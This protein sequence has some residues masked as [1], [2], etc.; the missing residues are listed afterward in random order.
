M[1]ALY[2]YPTIV[3]QSREQTEEIHE[4]MEIIDL[5]KP[6]VSDPDNKN[7][8]KFYGNTYVSQKMKGLDL[9]QSKTEWKPFVIIMVTLCLLVMLLVTILLLIVTRHAITKKQGKLNLNNFSNDIAIHV[10]QQLSA[11]FTQRSI[12]LIRKTRENTKKLAKISESLS[13][14]NNTT[15]STASTINDVLVIVKELLLIH[16]Q[17]SGP[18]PISCQDIKKKQLNSPSGYYN[19]NGTHIYCNM[20][21][22]CGSG[23]GW[24]R[25]AYLNMS[26]PAQNCPSGLRLYLSGAVRACSRPVSNDGSCA[27]VQF[28]SNGIR[29]SQI[30][31]R[32]VGYQ[33]GR[34]NALRTILCN[35]IS[36]TINSSY[37][38]GVS[39]TRG[40]SRQHVWTFA[41]GSSDTDMESD[42]I[43][44]CSSGSLSVQS[45]IGSHYFCESGNHKMPTEAK[46]ILYT[47]D[48]LWDG[49]GCGSNEV[50]CCS[51]PGIPWFHRDYG[52]STTTDYIEFRVCCNQKTGNED[53]PVKY[54][55][56]Y[57]K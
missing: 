30:C 5:P 19:I 55:E 57:V 44:P 33:Y 31:G 3:P 10:A 18:N 14:L 49:Q 21:E 13:N 1:A 53:V 16:N 35:D 38:D 52:S 32:V 40:S 47:S 23:G 42:D 22:L 20:E 26:D 39:I 27:S 8:E 15:T 54:Y 41:S 46:S 17:S 12:N 11:N 7:Y 2:D 4:Y 37:V 36:T 48:P 24:I 43:C 34:T 29:Y 51:A 9:N 28:P 6:P 56:I 25:L 45:F 50:T